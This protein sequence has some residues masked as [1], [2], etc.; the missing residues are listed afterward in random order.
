MLS[1]PLNLSYHQLR[2]WLGA[3]PAQME[4]VPPTEPL[5]LVPVGTALVAGAV[6]LLNLPPSSYKLK[7]EV[8]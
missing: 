1:V 2:R 3:A 5:V 6:L 4:S 7:A 8:I